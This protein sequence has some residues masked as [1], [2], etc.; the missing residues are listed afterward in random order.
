M[1]IPILRKKINEAWRHNSHVVIVIDVAVFCFP[2]AYGLAYTYHMTCVE[3]ESWLTTLAVYTIDDT[4]I[5]T[6]TGTGTNES[7]C[8]F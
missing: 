4:H 7:S 2:A 1:T 5:P 3:L 6:G 8:E